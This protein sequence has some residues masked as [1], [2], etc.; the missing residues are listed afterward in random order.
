MF[1]HCF[2]VAKG[3]ENQLCNLKI[4]FF[5][6]LLSLLFRTIWIVCGPLCLMN[7]TTVQWN[8]FVYFHQTQSTIYRALKSANWSKDYQKSR[9]FVLIVRAGGFKVK[10]YLTKIVKFDMIFFRKKARVDCHFLWDSNSGKLLWH[11]FFVL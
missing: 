11:G 1:A 6:R 5:E 8:I 10:L 7:S 9:S 4:K 3:M 2:Q